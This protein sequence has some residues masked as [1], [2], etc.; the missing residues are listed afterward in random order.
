MEVLGALS[1]SPYL[2]IEMVYNLKGF[3]MARPLHHGNSGNLTSQISDNVNVTKCNVSTL[4]WVLPVNVTKVA[5]IDT[6]TARA[7]GVS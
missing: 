6:G 2:T 7:C 5:G 1:T 3:G 4:S